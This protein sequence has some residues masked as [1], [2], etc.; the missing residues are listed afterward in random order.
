MSKNKYTRAYRCRGRFYF[1]KGDLEKRIKFY[2]KALEISPLF[3][4]IWFTLGCVYLRVKNWASAVNALSKSVSI[5]DSSSETWANLGIS[6]SQVGKIKEAVK[7]LDQ[8]LKIGRNNWKICENL[9][10]FAI[11]IKDLKKVIYCVNHLFSLDKFDRVK[12][13]VFYN[14]TIIYISIFYN[15][16]AKQADYY[17]LKIYQIFEKFSI[18]DGVTPEVW[19]LYAFFIES[20][21]IELLNMR[22]E[23]K[24][25]NINAVENLNKE[26]NTNSTNSNNLPVNSFTPLSDDEKE[27]FYQVIMEVRLKQIRSLMI[28]DSWD[29]NEQQVEK[30]SK[31]LDKLE[32]EVKRIKKI[33]RKENV[34]DFVN[35]IKAKIKKFYESK[36]EVG[37]TLDNSE[38][39]Q[40]G[41]KMEEIKF[42]F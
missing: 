24:L 13:D 5:D 9:M 26:E 35:G 17:K 28:S 32:Q 6:F 8:A 18:K 30:V 25:D 36:D 2:E 3:P 4:N 41:D 31:V 33:E 27:E 34:E 42:N 23:M 38:V 37:N 11:Q 20:A 19:D 40:A 39:N 1:A 10:H 22:K 16:T 29:K 14:L 7:C 15:I 21:E 12:P